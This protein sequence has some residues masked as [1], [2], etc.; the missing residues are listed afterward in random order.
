MA[1]KTVSVLVPVADG[2]EE[3]EAICLIDTLRRAGA[4]VTGALFSAV[5]VVPSL[6]LAIAVASVSD[7]QVVVCSRNTK[8]VAD[9]T[10]DKCKGVIYDLIALPGGLQGT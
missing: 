2:S 1:Q 4:V 8:I 6:F 9:T 7:S 3:I 10:I 5:R